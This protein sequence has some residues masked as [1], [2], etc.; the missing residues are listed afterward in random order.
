MTRLLIAVPALLVVGALAGMIA[1]PDRASADQPAA[2]DTLAV[3]GVG[4]VK[5]APDNASFSFGVETRGATAKAALAENGAQA[6]KLIAA[7][8]GAGARDLATQY[9]SVWP[10]SDDG[11]IT[12]YSASNSVSATIGVDKAGDL[13]DAATAAGANNVSGPEL[14]PADAEQVYRQALA[15]AVKDAKARAEALAKA[16][17]RSLGKIAKISEG[18]EQAVPYYEKAALGADSATPIE[19]GKQETSATVSVTFELR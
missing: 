6:R 14:S 4:S 17:G 1:T 8:R 11:S 7:L 19:P 3:T 12:G 18:G 10:I 13:V 5:S 9:V 2:V 16:T 15:A